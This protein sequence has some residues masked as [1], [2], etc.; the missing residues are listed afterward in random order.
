M[1]AARGCTAV[2]RRPSDVDKLRLQLL[3]NKGLKWEWKPS[4]EISN[5]P[6]PPPPPP[7][8][9]CPP[10]LTSSAV[11]NLFPQPSPPK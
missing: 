8:K 5:H 11:P 6:Y 9:V 4:A 3:S 2:R 10:I 1:R 7:S